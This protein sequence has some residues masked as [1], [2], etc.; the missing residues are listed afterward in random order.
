MS[1]TDKTM[2]EEDEYLRSM[3]LL[4]LT[5]SCI[6]LV[7]NDV[8]DLLEFMLNKLTLER[9][10]KEELREMRERPR[11]RHRLTW[12]TF[13]DR[14]S[15]RIFRRMFRMTRDSFHELCCLIE[16]CVGED[17]FKSESYLDNRTETATDAATNAV[18]G[19]LSGEMKVAMTI[20]L[21]AG[22]SYLDI[23]ASYATGE[24]VVYN[25]FHEVVRWINSTFNFPLP[26]SLLERDGE[27]GSS[28]ENASLSSSMFHPIR[29]VLPFSIRVFNFEL[30]VKALF[31]GMSVVAVLEEHARDVRG[32]NRTYMRCMHCC[33]CCHCCHC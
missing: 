22:G 4:L 8:E 9:R 16:K 33:H 14:F 5:I 20:R 27:P 1:E 11:N 18:G 29:A 26:K 13:A 23:L 7:D 15:D 2:L 3:E 28:M 24:T 32:I 30:I 6:L 10:D 17:V 12:S 25:S 19:V 31:G 21:L